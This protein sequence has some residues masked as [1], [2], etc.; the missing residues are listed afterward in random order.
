[1]RFENSSQQPVEIQGVTSPH[2]A[3]SASVLPV[4]AGKRNV[5]VVTVDPRKVTAD[6]KASIEVRTS[7]PQEQVLSL[8]VFGVQPPK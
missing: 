5:I 8:N 4:E 2:P 6:L 3:V 1:V 7:H